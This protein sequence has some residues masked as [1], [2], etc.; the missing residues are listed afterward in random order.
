MNATRKAKWLLAKGGLFGLACF[1]AFGLHV[2]A[3]PNATDSKVA[4]TNRVPLSSPAPALRAT[5]AQSHAIAQ[6]Y[7][8]LPL[9][10]ERVSP[11][12]DNPAKFLARGNGYALFLANKEAVLELRGHDNRA[13]IVR[14]QLA[15]A[16]ASATFSASDALPGTS[17]YFIGNDST[18]WRSSVPQFRRVYENNVYQGINLVYYGTQGQLE[19]DFDVAPGADP[20]VI[21]LAFQGVS[22][23]H[24]DSL[25]QLV[26]NSSG[27]EIRLRQPVAYQEIA[28]TKKPV[29]VHYVL[30]NGKN[31]SFQ[32]AAYDAHST[33]VI[34]PILIYSTYVG[35]SNIDNASAIAVAPDKTAFIAGSTFSADY[36]TTNN[37]QF[38][39]GGGP[40]FPQDAF[41]TKISADGSA[42]VY[43]T[44]LGGKNEDTAGGIAVDN[45]GNAYVTGATIS[46]DFPVGPFSINTLCGAD[47]QCGASW[48]G[49]NL[50][51]TNGF[52]T[53]LNA[54]GTAILYSGFIG[55]Y[56]NVSGQSVAVDGN[57]N[58]YVTGSVTANI[59]PTVAIVPPATPPP[60]FPITVSAF[61]TT[62][63]A[64]SFNAYV[65]KIDAT[66]A[67]ILYSSYLGGGIEDIGYGIAVDGNANAYVTGLTYSP[68]F[69]TVAPLQGANA[70][71]GDAFVSKVNTNG[72]GAGSL[73]FST[74]LGGA[75]LDQ[76]NGIA[77]DS[78]GNAY[79]AGVTNSAAFGFTPSGVQ[80]TY[81]GQGDAFV[82]KLSTT[83]TLSYFTYLGGT[84]ADAATGI[85]VDTLGNAYVTGST[86]S[87]DFP[88]SGSVFQPAY[89]GGNADSFVAKLDPAGATL[90]YS[91]FLGGSNTELATGI[92]LDTDGSAYVT[93]QTC[94]QDFPLSNPVQLVPG[95]N[96]DAYVSKISILGGF[97]LNPGGLVFGAQSLNTTSAS[98][99]VTLT[100][101]DN[102]Q[103]ITSI[104]ITGANAADFADTT[105]CGAPLAIGAK[106][107]FTVTFTP[108]GNGIRKAQIV[109]TD[110]APGSPHIIG[111]TG[112]TSEVSLSTSSLFF[113]F[114]NVNVPSAPQDV[115]VTNSGSTPLTISFVSASG[116]FTE[117]DNCT[118]TPVPPSG[119]CVIQVVFTPTAAIASVGAITISDSGAGSPQVVMATGTGVLQPP[120]QVSSLTG[121]PSVPAGKVAQYG[122][123]VTSASGFSNSVALSC[124]APATM[125]CSISPPVVTP[126][127]QQ[128]L[129]AVM[130]VST[131]L[132]TSAPPAVGFKFNP[133][134]FLRPFGGTAL[135]WM[136][137]AMLALIVAGARRRPLTASFG[138]AVVLLLASVACGGGAAGVPS[139]TPAGTY[140]V[141]VTA[142]SGSVNQSIPVTLQVK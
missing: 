94:S 128:S 34:D 111:L 53:K 36:P 122:L 141:T 115:T 66:G 72:S 38:N 114:Q 140:Q 82:A 39:R 40:D 4:A 80:P 6:N 56:E 37:I 131:A 24:V 69:P 60:P 10:F 134:S 65:M 76:G 73:V 50:L 90:L 74:F 7:A 5:E 118:K 2:S 42:I 120:F 59:T 127:A 101:G 119:T 41:V 139:G 33:L 49:R 58:A 27:G 98:Q 86:V 9:A 136:L 113:G 61:Q 123:S 20:S 8:Q 29:P 22:R 47:G 81:K 99:V 16:N 96:C 21:Q 12:S 68:D 17:N 19:Y 125:V 110:S 57:F 129:A 132:R 89:G 107:T 109:I 91:S 112:N 3:A 13:S 46:P 88:T 92:A 63:G 11:N 26:V 116:D 138:F 95:G 105:T 106:C 64:G 130:T 62:I 135:L 104:A 137:A 25:G 87:T 54:A 71:A 23:L 100:N 75:G 70:G 142:T 67:T 35:G 18:K 48:N 126:T 52:I 133:P 97:D 78:A 15:G 43:S 32:V 84:K 83:G 30:K 93:G 28:G 31:V 51:V 103:T 45:F 1:F 108:S 102:P 14:M 55:E 121:T 79:V 124:T 85:A 77:L 44:Y 117:S